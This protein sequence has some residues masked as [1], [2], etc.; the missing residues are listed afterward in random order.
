[1][2]TNGSD[3]VRTLG[4]AT[5]RL[6]TETVSAILNPAG[7]CGARGDLGQLAPRK[8]LLKSLSGFPELSETLLALFGTEG[9][10]FYPPPRCPIRLRR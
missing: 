4:Q 6:T 3:K 2:L 10:L 5:C 9:F 1:M 7:G 8:K